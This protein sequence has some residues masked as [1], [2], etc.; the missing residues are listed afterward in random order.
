MIA[1]SYHAA[2]MGLVLAAGAR[3]VVLLRVA[4]RH[5]VQ[6]CQESS[7]SKQRR[8]GCHK[9][10]LRGHRPGAAVATRIAGWSRRTWGNPLRSPVLWLLQPQ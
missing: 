1:D 3:G 10:N 4:C 6:L 2:A 8:S 5:Y 9:R 7:H